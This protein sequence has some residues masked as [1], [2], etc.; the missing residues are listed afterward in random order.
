[1]PDA[2]EPNPPARGALTSEFW[3]TVV[4]VVALVG[5]TMA[6]KVDGNWVAGAIAFACFGYAASRGVVKAAQ[7]NGDAKVTGFKTDLALL[8]L[9]TPTVPDE[10]VDKAVDAVVQAPP[11]PVKATTRTRKG[12]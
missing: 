10:T 9:K 3:L 5:L 8:A 12:G 4:G 11:A 6:D 2:A 7:V 1:M